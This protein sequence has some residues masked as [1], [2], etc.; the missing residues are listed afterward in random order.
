MRGSI[1]RRAAAVVVAVCVG[2]T[3]I[4]LAGDFAFAVENDNNTPAVEPSEPAAG[5]TDPDP[6]VTDPEADPTDPVTDPMT[7]DGDDLEG[8][9]GEGDP[10]GWVDGENGEKYYYKDG[11][12]VE[13]LQTIDG[14]IYY[15]GDDGIMQTGFVK[16]DNSL[17]YFFS[18]GKA[19]TAK[20]WFAIEGTSVKDRYGLGGG[21]IAAGPYGVSSKVSYKAKVKKRYKKRGKWRTKYVKVTRTK[22]VV[23]VYWFDWDN[24]QKGHGAGFFDDN[25]KSYY[26]KGDGVLATGW[27]ALKRDGNLNGYYFNKSTGAMAKG[28]TIGHLK[29]PANGK[30]HEAYALGIQ[31]LN[32]TGWSL[33]Q[34]YK[35]S[36]RIKYQG[37]WWRQSSSEKYAMKGFKYNKGNCYVMAATF[38][39]QAKLL[40]YNVRQIHG[41]VAYRAP[42]SWTQIYNG[43]SWR[44]YDPN[45]RNETGRN[46]WNIYYGKKGTWRYTNYSVFQH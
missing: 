28:T 3:F 33:R 32:K 21:K 14:D 41:K 10:D 19:T 46:G 4:P 44:V 36:Y 45:F 24:G 23:T 9:D 7:K 1:L 43:K 2:V 11:Q 15:F 42:H 12:P 27:Q 30:L 22:T 5:P 40:G 16:I 39:I 34:A 31:K 35:N 8:D 18:D 6:V 37:R 13:G 17:Y 25:G 20:T 26:C 38:Y 29:I